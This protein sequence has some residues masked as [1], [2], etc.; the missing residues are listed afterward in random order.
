MPSETANEVTVVVGDEAVEEEAITGEVDEVMIDEILIGVVDGEMIEIL[1]AVV[2]EDLNVEALDQG[3][4]TFDETLGIVGAT[5]L[6][7]APTLISLEV[8]I[9]VE[10]GMYDE[11][12]QLLDH[13]R[14]Y[15]HALD[16]IHALRHRAAEG[17]HQ[18][19]APLHADTAL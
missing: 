12:Q 14:Q 19:L 3:H 10:E 9:M 16:R 15:L 2:V 5:M 1:V 8:A 6:G 7:E 13:L 11:D 4:H 18:D 17:R